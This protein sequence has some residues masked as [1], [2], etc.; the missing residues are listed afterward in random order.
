MRTRR[1]SSM[2]TLMVCS[3]LH[4]GTIAAAA[5]TS[6]PLAEAIY[7]NSGDGLKSQFAD[8]VHIYRSGDQAAFRVV[9]D[10][11]GIPSPPQ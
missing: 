10:S 2:L 3:C 11:L 8:L 4:I 5:Q 6:V 7:A 1:V 9:L